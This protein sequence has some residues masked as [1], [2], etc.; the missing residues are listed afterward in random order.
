MAIWLTPC[1][2]LPAQSAQPRHAGRPVPHMTHRP[3][4]TSVRSRCCLSAAKTG[5]ATNQKNSPRATT[6]MLQFNLLRLSLWLWK[7]E[8][9]CDISKTSA[10]HNTLFHELMIH[11]LNPHDVLLKAQSSGEKI[12]KY[13]IAAYDEFER[14]VWCRFPTF[15]KDTAAGASECW[16]SDSSISKSPESPRCSPWSRLQRMSQ[17]SSIWQM[18][19]KY[20]TS[21]ILKT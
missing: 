6:W 3:W 7:F 5:L 15:P 11:D 4:Q 20:C 10:Y 14:Q 21:V 12:A 16:K 13:Q 8:A 9:D 2:L 18:L 19:Q 17:E 1:R